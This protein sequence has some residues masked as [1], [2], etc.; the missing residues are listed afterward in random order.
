MQQAIEILF[1]L[2]RAALHPERREQL[3]DR[4]VPDW[5][6]IYRL[7]TEQGVSAVAWDGL[8]RLRA[9]GALTQAMELPLRLKLQWALQVEGIE[10]RY[11]DQLRSATELA[12]L[13][14]REGI[15]T[16]V[17]KGFS[18]SELYP[19]PMHRECGDLDCFLGDDYERGNRCAEVAGGA[20]E[21][22][23]YKH[24]HITYKGL[25]VEN[26]R[27]CTAIRGRSER[28]ALERRLQQLLSLSDGKRIAD[29]A[30][31]SPSAD[32]NALFLTAHGFF[33]FLNEGVKLR[34]LCDW[35]LL[36]KCCGS[37][38][39]WHGYRQWCDRMD[40]TRFAA[41]MTALAEQ[42]LALAPC[43][44]AAEA[45]Q[46]LVE[47]LLADMLRDDQAIYNTGKS[48]FKQRLGLI[49]NRLQGHWKYRSIY[50]RS[51]LVDLTAMLW[52]YNFEKNPTLKRE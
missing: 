23:Y 27:F 36:V 49:T 25:A 7:A 8:Q 30:L 40:F 44:L 17:L 22:S 12:T 14:A 20:V 11:A 39:D 50:R 3:D 43:A 19:V 37:E 48:R 38:I 2:L 13:F 33:H 10:K 46:R 9:Q 31:E 29:T 32:F 45:D 18:L 16:T 41:T 35:M 51:M 42:L 28:K 34:H 1:L 24:A 52:A 21:R 47:R 26:H 6:M 4:V 15:R 5:P